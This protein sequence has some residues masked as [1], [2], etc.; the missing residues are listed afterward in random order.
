M[1]H[2]PLT[3]APIPKKFRA[4]FVTQPV[5]FQ[6]LSLEQVSSPHETLKRWRRIVVA[7]CLAGNR[8]DAFDCSVTVSW[9]G[10]TS[11][12]LQAPSYDEAGTRAVKPTST[13]SRSLLPREECRMTENAPYPL[14][15]I[16]Y[17]SNSHTFSITPYHFM[18]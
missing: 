6:T 5:C 16:P 7:P 17:P 2:H 11:S 3:L 12:S 4:L 15:P 8:Q 10:L 13:A 9:G 14:S 1:A 18:L